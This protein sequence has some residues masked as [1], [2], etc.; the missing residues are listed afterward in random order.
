MI[1]AT[2]PKTLVEFGFLRGHSALNFLLAMDADATLYSFD[3]EPV[4]EDAARG[5]SV[6]DTRLRFGLK[7]QDE[8]T[9]EDVDGRPIDFAFFDASHDL[10]TNQRTFARIEDLLAR[11]A[12]IAVHDTG[13]W[14]RDRIQLSPKAIGYTEE[15]PDYWLPSGDFAHRPDERRFVNWIGEQRPRFNQ[16][17]FHSDSTL[18]HGLTLLQAGGPLQT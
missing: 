4:A 9:A 17:H 1:K 11:R 3:V 7:S 13:A 18:R 2:R 12:L 15:N 5:L 16:I 8:I 10:A 14:A 6:R